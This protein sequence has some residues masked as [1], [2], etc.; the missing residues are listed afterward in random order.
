MISRKITTEQ[1]WGNLQKSTETRTC[2]IRESRANY[3]S[4]NPPFLGMWASYNCRALQGLK[5]QKNC[6]VAELPCSKQQLTY[7][8]KEQLHSCSHTSPIYFNESRTTFICPL[9][10]FHLDQWRSYIADPFTKAV[11]FTCIKRFAYLY[12]LLYLKC[13]EHITAMLC[14][15]RS[16][17][18][19]LPRERS[20]LHILAMLRSVCTAP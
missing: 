15:L 14:F 17:L 11:S 13:S 20:N 12:S 1:C 19:L 7:F 9:C 18:P 16:S 4:A 3:A 8:P 5:V 10:I 2:F 6:A